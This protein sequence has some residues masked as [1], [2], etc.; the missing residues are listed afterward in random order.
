MKTQVPAV[1]LIANLLHPILLI[2]WYGDWN[3]TFDLSTDDIGIGIM[4][5]IYGILLSIP[6]L[7]LGFF[8]EYL[9][10]KLHSSPMNRYL[11]WLLLSPLAAL[12]NW[13]FLALVFGGKLEGDDF[14]IALPSMV[15]VI[16]AS[17][18]RYRSFMK[19]KESENDPSNE[20]KN[21]L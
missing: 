18:F 5:F 2:S 13:I 12:L 8:V 9:V 1:W 7:F 4:I 10:S 6:S 17:L 14:S 21:P 15:S 11:Y 20:Q 19:V 3:L 16:L